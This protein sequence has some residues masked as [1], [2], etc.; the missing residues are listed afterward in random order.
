MEQKK[1]S[2]TVSIVTITQHSRLKFMPLLIECIQSQ[3]YP[4]MEWVIVEGSQTQEEADQNQVFFKSISSEKIAIRYLPF[5]KDTK[6]GGLRNRGNQAC[7]GDII[8][9]M[10][11]DDYYPPMRVSHVI[12]MFTLYPKKNLAGCTKILLYDY[13]IKQLYQ[14]TGFSENHATNNTMAWR[15]EYHGI[16]DESKTFGEES[17]FTNQ[18]TEPMIQLE[19]KYTVIVS[20]HNKNTFD[21]RD[22]IKDH[23]LFFK[24]SHNLLLR[25]MPEEV[26]EKY[27]NTIQI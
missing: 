2:L 9:C 11:D 14:C 19:S 1:F 7:R 6:L 18:F 3:M 21:K 26:Y 4:I 23:P 15:K 22:M 24:L 5:V 20:S 25:F 12:D 27:V 17:S 8:V 16:H 13:N 10:D